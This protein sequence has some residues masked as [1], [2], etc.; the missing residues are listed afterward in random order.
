MISRIGLQGLAC[1]P[2]SAWLLARML[3]VLSP[4][5]R[6]QVTGRSGVAEY[7]TAFSSISWAVIATRSESPSSPKQHEQKLCT[8]IRVLAIEIPPAGLN[9]MLAPS[10]SDHLLHMLSIARHTTAARVRQEAQALTLRRMRLH[11]GR[12][13]WDFGPSDPSRPGQAAVGRTRLRAA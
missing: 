7:L 12:P 6:S 3:T 10:C 1:G 11:V 9:V 8:K 13:P 2:D 5:N 4:S